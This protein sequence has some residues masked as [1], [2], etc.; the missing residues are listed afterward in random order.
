MERSNLRSLWEQ[1][2]ADYD[3]SGQTIKAWCREQSI[4]ESQFYYWRKKLREAQ[5]LYDN[6]RFSRAY[7]LLCIC[8]KELGKSVMIASAIVDLVDGNIDWKKFWRRLRNHKDK[9][10]TLEHMEN[11]FILGFSR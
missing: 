9:T 5:I 4:R 10:G 8:N 1:R 3:V 6:E 2:L 7:F 11:I